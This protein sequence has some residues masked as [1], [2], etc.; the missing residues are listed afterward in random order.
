LSVNSRAPYLIL[1]LLLA[2]CTGAPTPQV[3][4]FVPSA[5]PGAL[6]PTRVPTETSIPPTAT[7]TA[8]PQPTDTPAPTS[9]P[10]LTPSPQPTD[11]PAP[12]N[13]P[14]PATPVAQALR[15]LNVRGGP[16]SQYPIIGN[17]QANQQLEIAGVSDDGSWFQV[18]MPDGSQGWITSA[19]TLITT[20]GDIRGVPVAE[21]PTNTPTNTPQPSVTPTNTP[22]E[23]PTEEPTTPAATEDVTDET[24]QVLI[25][26]QDILD[27]LK[28]AGVEQ[29]R[30]A[31]A[32]KIDEKVID[33]TGLDNQIQWTRF[34]GTYTN[35]VAGATIQ[36]GPGDPGDYCGFVFR[37]VDKS[38]FYTAQID[39]K[40]N[41]WFDALVNDKWDDSV[42]GDGSD[43]K[44]GA[45]D[46]NQV[47]ILGRNDTFTVYINGRNATT[48]T[49]KQFTS[50]RVGVM[51]GTNA[52]SDKTNCTFTNGWL[53][54][55]E[56]APLMANAPT[57]VAAALARANI[58]GGEL[59]GQIASK[60]IDLSG[61]DNVVQWENFK[62]SYHNFVIG[63]TIQWGP[64][65]DTD[66]C[67]VLLRNAD[68]KNL[69]A[70]QIDRQ[71]RLVLSVK[72]DDQWQ[73]DLNGSGSLIKTG[74]TDTNELV[75]VA[76]D[77]SFLVYLNGQYA[78]KF[79]D[80]RI[81]DGAVGI[82]AGTFEGSDKSSCTF[83]NSW[84]WKLDTP[85]SSSL[86]DFVSSGLKTADIPETE[87]SLAG[88]VDQKVIDLTGQD[89]Q[90]QWQ[91]FTGKYSDFVI[92]TTIQW[93]PGATED[94]CGVIVRQADDDNLYLIQI[95]RNNRLYFSAKLNGEWQKDVD[96]DGKLIR[97]GALDQNE[98]VVVGRGDTFEVY[99]NGAF[100]TQF[101]ETH[102]PNGKA[103]ILAGT[104][105]K[106]D[107]TNCT[108][109]NSWLWSLD[110]G[111]PEATPGSNSS[112][113]DT[114]LFI[115][116]TVQGTIQG[117]SA[118]AQYVFTASEGDVVSIR[119]TR[120]SGDLDPVLILL[121]PNG[122]EIARAD[123]AAN[124][125]NRDALL[126]GI[127]LPANGT[128]TIIATRFQ[129]D[130]GLTSGD[131]SLSLSRGGQ[132]L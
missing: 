12:T 114:E 98:L 63:T 65:A 19:S 7:N 56:A 86:P 24:P 93:G 115:G 68:D 31:L 28:T 91:T 35:F 126:Q 54:D 22:T 104:F 89:N 5:T 16:G 6:V 108:F 18:V 120:Q 33:L 117:T 4:S 15:S 20:S 84:L 43:V 58:T 72:I 9:T 49:D 39:R 30:G 109:T 38:N 48:F 44:T 73:K 131:F 119:M 67:G 46:T 37:E 57:Y 10:T 36:W 122:K 27:A 111:S 132:K 99:L 85:E 130:A 61:K 87:G 42:S 13:T 128:Y 11:T 88:Q 60:T 26:S 23:T 129:E 112:S 62:D 76:Q 79:T 55:M 51:A 45:T 77:D 82:L 29:N 34:N 107:K 3:V 81:T 1:L 127:T 121:D 97:N 75:V 21:A 50:G 103:G 32:D 123:D 25:P 105:E 125:T 14:T 94:Y 53:W 78:D 92:G 70:L 41:L 47:V 59:A 100:A 64:G 2:A 90:V 52:N 113:A 74:A 83:S 102:V 69:Y 80:N 110:A 17:L 116:D 66:Y 106:S 118:S 71:G 8:T 95:D 96:G 101:K 40:G 124:P